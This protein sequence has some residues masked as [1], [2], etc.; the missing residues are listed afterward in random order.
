M[1]A[2]PD[3]TERIV[4]LRRDL[5]RFPELSCEEHRTMGRIADELRALGI[6]PRV[7][8]AGTGVVAELP[9]RNR[10][11]FVALRADTDALP[12]HEET[13]LPFASQ[14][15]GVMHACGH[16]GHTSMLV[17]AAAMLLADPPPLP[18]RLIFQPA[19]EKGVGAKNM[20]AEGVLEGVGLIFGGHLDRHY[21]PGTLVVTDGPVN[22]STDTFHIEIRGQQGHGARPHEAIDAIVIGSLLVTALQTVVSREVDPA[23]PSVVTVG[24]FEAG[25]AP[26][27]IAGRAT[28]EGTIRAQHHDVRDHL[29]ESIQR[30]A[31]AVGALHRAQIDVEV[32]Y[33]TPPVVNHAGPTALARRAAEELVGPDRVTTLHTANMGGE[34]FAYYLE[35]I[36][37]C[38]IRY[39]A[40]VPGREGYPAH[41]SRFDIHEDA[42]PLGAAWLDR[43]ARVGGAHLLGS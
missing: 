17:G 23:R 20:I 43:V 28:L 14:H 39:G 10:G 41:S 4:A 21:A 15:A 6:T 42:L 22:A 8:V 24:R 38:Y 33:G 26:N 32:H 2:P 13:G 31:K 29:C 9:G 27:V 35:K 25:S 1:T 18:V 37:G 7:G 40:Q 3:I 5:H 12:V 19:E 30:I 11:P 36:P 16:D 34:D